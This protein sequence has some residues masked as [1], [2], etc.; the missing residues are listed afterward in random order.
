VFGGGA[1]SGSMTRRCGSLTGVLIDHMCFYVSMKS[2][3]SILDSF[4][5]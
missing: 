3:P 1:D 2:G 5:F 4:Y